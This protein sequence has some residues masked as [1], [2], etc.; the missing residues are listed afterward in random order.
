MFSLSVSVTSAL[1]IIFLDR[2]F[3]LKGQIVFFGQLQS[4]SSG[5]SEFVDKTFLLCDEMICFRFGV[6]R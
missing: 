5:F 1:Y 2:H 4:F 3:P 6:V